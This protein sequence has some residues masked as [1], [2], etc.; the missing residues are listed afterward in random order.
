MEA[1]SQSDEETDASPPSDRYHEQKTDD[2]EEID[3]KTRKK[4]PARRLSKQKRIAL[5][6]LR[7]L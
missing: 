5:A 4:G 3:G 1:A 7:K 6:A 2:N